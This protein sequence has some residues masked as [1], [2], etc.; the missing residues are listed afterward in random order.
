MTHY[1]LQQVGSLLRF[2]TGQQPELVPC[3]IFLIDANFEA[4][5]LRL[6]AY[7]TSINN[8]H[9]SHP[10]QVSSMALV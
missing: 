7:I 8:S 2:S 4:F 9:N 1:T 3:G 10:K 6:P 5:Y